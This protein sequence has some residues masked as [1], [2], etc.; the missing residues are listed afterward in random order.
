MKIIPLSLWENFDF[1]TKKKER[2]WEEMS[3]FVTKVFN[4]GEWNRHHY[5][6]NILEYNCIFG[7][8]EWLKNVFKINC[9]LDCRSPGV[10][11]SQK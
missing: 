9:L 3:Y 5:N 10:G 2:E 7:M 11:P 8:S 1:L 6:L 4:V